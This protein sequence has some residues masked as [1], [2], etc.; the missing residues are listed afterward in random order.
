MEKRKGNPKYKKIR[1]DGRWI[2]ILRH[3]NIVK[4]HN[5]SGRKKDWE[6]GVVKRPGRVK[7]YLEKIYG[8][9]AFLPNG[10]IRMPYL[11]KE[12]NI[13]EK[14]PK[15]ERPE[16]LLHALYLAKTFKEMAARRRA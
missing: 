8:N 9:S 5:F 3:K 12:I 4:H 11:L 2:Y 6:E 10:E 15:I 13:L 1:K 14:L 7:N 16:S